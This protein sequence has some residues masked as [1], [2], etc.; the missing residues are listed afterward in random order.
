M[1]FRKVQRCDGISGGESLVGT[2]EFVGN[3]GAVWTLEG[4]AS[5][6]VAMVVDL[7]VGRYVCAQPCDVFVNHGCIYHEQITVGL[8]AVTKQIIDDPARLIKHQRVLAVS[9]A[10]AS[11]VVG[12]KAFK[13]MLRFWSGHEDFPHVR[14]IEK[15]S[16][17]SYGMVLRDDSLILDGHP[18]SSEADHSGAK[19]FVERGN[20]GALEVGFH[21]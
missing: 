7:Y 17:V 19:G 9:D 15:A 12:E 2:E 10:Q 1:A 21:E 11:D 5:P 4:E 3:R 6:S 14:D 20:R 18:P 16:R 13:E 8:Q